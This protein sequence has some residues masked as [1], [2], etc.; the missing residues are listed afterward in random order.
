MAFRALISFSFL[1]SVVMSSCSKEE[2]LSPVSGQPNMSLMKSSTE[3]GD[4][5]GNNQNGDDED[6]DL[7]GKGITDP[8]SGDDD[9]ESSNQQ[10]S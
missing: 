2:V 5:N 7:S 9:D 8:G 10:T 6:S 1:L 4:R 3:A